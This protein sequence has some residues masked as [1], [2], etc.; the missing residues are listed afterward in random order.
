[1]HDDA[2]RGIMFIKT[3][4]VNFCGNLVTLH[5][6]SSRTD[7]EFRN[8]KK[9][10]GCHMK[11][12]SNTSNTSPNKKINDEVNELKTLVGDINR[13]IGGVDIK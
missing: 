12:S 13:K 7:E 5:S 6:F 3:V 2:C 4:R 1:M 11:Q 9:G 8:L 10:I